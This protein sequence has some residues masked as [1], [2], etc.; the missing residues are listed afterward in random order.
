MVA[1]HDVEGAALQMAQR[2]LG[3]G[4]LRDGV[5]VGLAP[6]RAPEREVESPFSWLWDSA[7]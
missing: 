1:E 6:L 5:P 3:V 4:G 2:L 7:N